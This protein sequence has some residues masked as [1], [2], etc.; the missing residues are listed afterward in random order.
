VA[1]RAPTFRTFAAVYLGIVV[2]TVAVGLLMA[3]LF[4]IDWLRLSFIT[5][6]ALF[7][8]SIGGRPWWLY[9]PIRRTGW[10]ALI[11]NERSMRAVLAVL[12][13][14][15]IVIGVLAPLPTP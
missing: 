8:V 5:V 4:G 15:L 2:G 10:F 6:G 11:R 7:L 13:V 3:S 1:G 12:G 9:A 14:L